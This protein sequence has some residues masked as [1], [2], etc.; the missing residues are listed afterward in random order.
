MPTLI[1]LGREAGLALRRTGFRLATA[2][3]CTGGLIG[4]VVTETPGSSD[5]FSG[6]IVSYSNDAKAALLGVSSVTL[7]QQGAVSAACA[8]EMA[9]GA[10]LAF[11]ADVAL[12]VTGI[13]GPGGGSTDKPTGTVFITLAT[14]Q[15]TSQTWRFLWQSDRS[16]N[17]ALSAAAALQILLDYLQD[18]L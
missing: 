14:R 4:H 5:Y 12:S 17:K 8:A 13:A 15:G 10:L 6:G 2:E 18:R 7:Q 9:S 3:S 11:D 1:A 16:G